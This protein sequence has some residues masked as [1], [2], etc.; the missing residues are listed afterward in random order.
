MSYSIYTTE[1]IILKQRDYGEA[2][3]IYSFFT[4][5]FGKVDIRAQGIR[6]LKSKLRYNLSGSSFIRIAFVDTANDYYRIIDAEEVSVLDNIRSDWWK[7]KFAINLFSLMIRLLGGQEA[8][9]DLWIKV[10]K[11]LLFLDVSKFD[12]NALKKFE[13]L[14][15]LRILAHLGYAEENEK[16]LNSSSLQYSLEQSQL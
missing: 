13:E 2:D 5:D 14:V 16:F 8:D 3:R 9:E 1:A 10:K 12:K 4:K 11:I 6:H 15:T 7:N